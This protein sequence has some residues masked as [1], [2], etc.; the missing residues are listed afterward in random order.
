MAWRKDAGTRYSRNVRWM[1]GCR[2]KVL[3]ERLV[4]DRT[5]AQ[6]TLGTSDGDE[7]AGTRYS[8]NVRCRCNG[9]EQ[10]G[11]SVPESRGVFVDGA[12]Y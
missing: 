4:E 11:S 6:G 5:L 12:V 8:G 2:H 3:Q 1:E 9:A 10:I 7:D